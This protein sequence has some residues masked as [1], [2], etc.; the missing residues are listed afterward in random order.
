[1]HLLEV[2]TVQVVLGHDIGNRVDELCA[3]RSASDSGTEVSRACPA[4]D[5]NSDACTLKA[6]RSTSGFQTGIDG[7]KDGH[8]P[9]HA[10]AERHA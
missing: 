1:M 5:G 3:I 6:M 2:N 10:R 4:T 9:L 7:V 8:S